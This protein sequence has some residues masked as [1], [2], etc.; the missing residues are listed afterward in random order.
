MIIFIAMNGKFAKDLLTS[1]FNMYMYL[2]HLRLFASSV[3]SY[4]HSYD[5]IISCVVWLTAQAFL[6]YNSTLISGNFFQGDQDPFLSK[7]CLD[8]IPNFVENSTIRYTCYTLCLEIFMIS[9][10]DIIIYELGAN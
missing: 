8:F 2:I 10:F 1:Y 6:Q 5:V 3:H 9:I 7:K 4:C